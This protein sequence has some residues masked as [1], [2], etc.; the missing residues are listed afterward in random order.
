MDFP[1]SSRP[2]G[3]EQ[4]RLDAGCR[5]RVDVLANGLQRFADMIGAVKIDLGGV[6]PVKLRSHLKKKITL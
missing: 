5:R 1:P 6:K 4:L 2:L 3:Y